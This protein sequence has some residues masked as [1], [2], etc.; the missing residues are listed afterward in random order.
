MKIL[1]NFW[2]I[3]YILFFS[4]IILL[5]CAQDSIFYDISFEPEPKQPLIP[6][7][8][9]NIAVLRNQVFV[10][11]R[12]SDRVFAYGYGSGNLDWSR[13]PSL[14]AS[15]G[16]LATDGQNLYALVFPGGDPLRS[17]VIRRF[18]FD[19]LTWESGISLEGFS[20][21]TL[22][23]AGG[24]IFAGLQSNSNRQRYAIAQYNTSSNSLNII[25][26]DTSLLSG[27]STGLGSIY[28][29]TAGN[30]LFIFTGSNAIGPMHGTS[31]VS[32]SGVAG[33]GDNVVAVT[34]DGRVYTYSGGAFTSVSVG[35]HF[36]GALNVWLDPNNGFRPALL[37]M[38]IRARGSSMNQGYREMVLVNGNPTF[39]IKA[40]GEGFPTSVTSRSVYSAGVGR[41]PV[42]YILQVPDI[43][44]GGPLDYRIFTS[45]PGWEPPIFASTSR[46]GLWS[47]R[48]GEWNAED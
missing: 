26:D 39:E 15:L 17:S 19:N 40:P 12:M 10:G 2:K 30:G 3:P 22:Y 18:N 16:E 38:G 9:T 37:L 20:I 11:S 31:S 43:S 21:Q 45:E 32:F 41:H 33:V 14:N 46:N 34:S 27:A 23:G 1:N 48:S 47:Y 7:G 25:Q 13:L 28:L 6:G 29:V 4:G 24:S 8:P 36:T 35:V 5:S 42:E 44:D